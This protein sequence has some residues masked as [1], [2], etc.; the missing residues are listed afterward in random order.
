MKVASFELVDLELVKKIAATNLPLF[1][2]TGMASIAE[3]DA[4]VA[5]AR[6]AGTGEMVAFPLQQ[7]VSRFSSPRWTC[8][9]SP[10]WP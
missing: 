10:T 5:T 7:R 2:S 3:I 6:S 8:S 1:M 4:A 9:R